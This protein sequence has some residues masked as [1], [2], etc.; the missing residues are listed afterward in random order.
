MGTRRELDATLLSTNTTVS[1][2]SAGGLEGEGGRGERVGGRRGRGTVEKIL[3]DGYFQKWF[4][5]EM[6]QVKME[7]R[8]T[9]RTTAP[10]DVLK[11]WEKCYAIWVTRPLQRNI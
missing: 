6:G 9:K 11:L 3:V 7:A 10:I 5:W 8:K 2:E 4:R 1:E